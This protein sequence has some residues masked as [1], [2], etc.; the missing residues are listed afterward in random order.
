MDTKLLRHSQGFQWNLGA[1]LGTIVG[2]TL[3]LLILG[4]LIFNRFG[5]TVAGSVSVASALLPNLIALWLW[6]MRNRISPYMAMQSV[7]LTM[8]ICALTAILVI[9]AQ[10]L[11]NELDQLYGGF[12]AIYFALLI[13]PALM[14]QFWW[15]ERQGGRPQERSSE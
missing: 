2:G 3:W 1:W 13:Y 6:R 10:G 14:V 7:I 9:D 5:S 15:L 8:G 11:I 12:S 4:V